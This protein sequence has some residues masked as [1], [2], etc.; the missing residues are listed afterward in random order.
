MFRNEELDRIQES[1]QIQEE[2]LVVTIPLCIYLLF[3]VFL[4]CTM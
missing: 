3:Y 2:S 1:L 4:L